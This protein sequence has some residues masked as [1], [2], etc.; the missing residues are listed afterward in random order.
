M[1]PQ[2]LFPNNLFTHFSPYLFD[3]M[4]VGLHVVTDIIFILFLHV[5]RYLISVRQCYL[6]SI[7]KRFVL[8]ELS[9][10]IGP[11]AGFYFTAIQLDY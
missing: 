9:I 10:K 7:C 5:E 11:C 4:P 2:I 6:N 3:I 1:L 8:K